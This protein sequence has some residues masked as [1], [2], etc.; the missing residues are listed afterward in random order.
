MKTKNT[1]KNV[2]T[3]KTPVLKE[4]L[5]V[6]TFDGNDSFTVEAENA[7]D[8]AHKALIEL[9]WFVSE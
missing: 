1:K 2:K 4:Y 8:A 9:G 3:T 6:N 5:I 7:D